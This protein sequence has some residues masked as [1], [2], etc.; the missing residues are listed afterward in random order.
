M[1]DSVAAAERQNVAELAAAQQ[2]ALPINEA[3]CGHVRAKRQPNGDIELTAARRGRV[4]YPERLGVINPWDV[5]DVI[6]AL[7]AMRPIDD[8][9][10]RAEGSPD[11]F[12]GPEVAPAIPK[13]MRDRAHRDLDLLARAD[14]A[15]KDAVR[16]RLEELR[17]A[18]LSLLDGLEGW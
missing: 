2:P 17:L 5:D 8:L 18:L 9:I 7:Q 4:G 1:P 12:S 15:K 6:V 10:T 13:E 14:A 16:A 11:S 3:I